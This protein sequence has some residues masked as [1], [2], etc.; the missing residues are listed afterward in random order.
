[1]NKTTSII[2][3]AVLFAATSALAFEMPDNDARMSCTSI[4]VG[5]KASADGSVITSHTCD[6]NYRTWMDIVPS[7]DY[8]HDTLAVV[9]KG[10]MHT[11]HSTGARGMQAAGSVKVPGKSFAFLNTAYPCLNER[12]LGIG[13]TT[14]GG[15]KELENKNGLF[16]I[17]ELER[18]ALQHCTSAREAIAYMGALATEYGYG[19]SGECLTVADPQEVWHFE[20]FGA[21]PDSLGAVWAAVRIPDDHVGVS[22]NISRISEIDLSDKDRYMASDNVKELARRMGFWDGSEPFKFW[23]AYSGVNYFNEPKA[24][25]V[26]ELFILNQLAPSLGLNDGMEELP[27]SV[28]PEGSV[29]V[30]DVI[31]LLASTYEG[32][33]LD[34]T[35][36]LKITQ[37]K[38]DGS[39]DTITSPMANPW[40]SGDMI[41]LFNAVKDSTV[42]NVRNVSVPQCSYSTVIQ[43]RDWLPDAVGGVAWISLDNPGQSPR[44]PVFAGATDLPDSWK[45]DGQLRYDEN[46]AVWPYR[47]AN[48]LAT[49]KWGQTRQEMEGARKHFIDKGMIEMPFV[50]ETY[51]KILDAD[52]VEKANEFLTLYTADF[53]G[54]TSAKWNE[55]GNR[56]WAKFARGF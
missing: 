25:S 49:V 14:I 33:E 54:A 34:M 31:E 8:G 52:G 10:R 1:M 16:L 29:S 2:A 42:V 28:R 35:R 36:N 44:I 22:A 5:K 4:M 30:E 19:D 37:K 56:W 21:G 48:K 51:L 11:D 3:A 24:Y 23:K 46:A 20:I 15:R 18:L 41:K 26:R 39:L 43:L 9:V 6:G 13:E 12:Q 7:H 40:M 17:E 47:R 50:E 27:V 32:T 55:L 45:I 38:K 53:A